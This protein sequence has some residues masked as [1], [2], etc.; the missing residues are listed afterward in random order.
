M[1]DGGNDYNIFIDGIWIKKISCAFSRKEYI[2]ATNLS[3]GSH[4]L[5]LTKRTE[6]SFGA[7]RFD[8]LLLDEGKKLLPLPP[9]LSRKIE[10]IG[11]SISCG[12]GNEGKTISCPNL[13]EFENSYLTYGGFL[14]RELNAELSI[15]AYSGK[16]V[17][18]N[19]GDQTA[20]SREPMPLFW[21]APFSPKIT[22]RR[23]M[24]SDKIPAGRLTIMP[25]IVEAAAI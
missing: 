25:T 6:A 13:R 1:T 15:I 11:D 14:G 21:L 19:Y 22:L 10:I 20:Q 3:E 23:P 7:G 5:L 16:G 4:T 2:A 18:R 9:K 8:G 24:I 17:V 12:Y